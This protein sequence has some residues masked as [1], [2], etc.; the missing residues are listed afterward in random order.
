MIG[1]SCTMIPSSAALG[2][3]PALL[4]IDVQ[5]DTLDGG[6]LEIPG[7]SAAVGNI[8]R[9]CTAFRAAGRPIVHV[10]RLYTADGSNAEPVRRE[11]V[12]GPVP[13]LQPGTPG[14]GLAPG[15]LANAVELDDAKLLAGEMQCVGTYEHIVFKPRWGAFY[16]TPLDDYLHSIGADTIVFSGCNFPNC[17]RTSMY[18]ASERDYGI[19]LAVDATSGLYDRGREE[20]ANIGVNL[21]TVAEVETALMATDE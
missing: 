11:L 15:L 1:Q 5:V 3:R 18:E 8:G 21:A 9:L 4:T 20:M 7:T 2:G 17:P 12:R 10:V 19:V 13:I 6:P 16:N 14:R